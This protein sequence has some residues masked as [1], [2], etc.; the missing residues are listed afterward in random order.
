MKEGLHQQPRPR[1]PAYRALKRPQ[2]APPPAPAE[3]EARAGRARPHA[4][5][6][7]AT[8]QRCAAS[9]AARMALLP[10]AP[11]AAAAACA[12]CGPRA[13]SSCMHTGLQFGSQPPGSSRRPGLWVFTQQ[14]PAG[15]RQSG[16][17]HLTC[18]PVC[19]RQLYVR[20]RMQKSLL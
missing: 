18:G 2:H 1:R 10:P 4:R 8:P 19:T 17:A 5:P 20:Q 3:R 13:R 12:A 16:G 6:C 14:A 7:P 11:A 15:G 9:S